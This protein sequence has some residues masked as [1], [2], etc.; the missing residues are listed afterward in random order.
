MEKSVDSVKRKKQPVYF[1]EIRVEHISLDDLD[2]NVVSHLR[3]NPEVTT[4]IS[5]I[6]S[7]I[8]PLPLREQ[9]MML[10]NILTVSGYSQR[11]I[12]EALHTPYQEYRNILW[13]ARKKFTSENRK[14]F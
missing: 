5:D 12:A 7:F 9:A 10:T 3:Q 2:L 8:A 4:S 14:L 1:E 6:L 11:E 13:E